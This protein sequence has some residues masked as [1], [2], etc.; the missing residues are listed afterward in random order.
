M[1]RTKKA[2]VVEPNYFSNWG[3]L[4]YPPIANKFFLPWAAKIGWLTP[5]QVT[6]T[7]FVLYAV[8]VIGINFWPQYWNNTTLAY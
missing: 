7:S 6:I 2:S 8:A 1:S 5:N 3:D 4:W